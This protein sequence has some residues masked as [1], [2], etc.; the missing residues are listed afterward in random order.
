[1]FYGGFRK[2]GGQSGEFRTRAELRGTYLTTIEV[3]ALLAE[4]K[5]DDY[6]LG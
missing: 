4:R 5:L 2:I 6:L 3:P 1:M